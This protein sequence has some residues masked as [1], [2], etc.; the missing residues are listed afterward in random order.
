MIVCEWYD[1]NL[2]HQSTGTSANEDSTRD[3]QTPLQKKTGPIE[4]FDCQSKIHI[5][6]SDIITQQPDGIEMINDKADEN[7]TIVVHMDLPSNHTRPVNKERNVSSLD[8]TTS[9]TIQ[10]LSDSYWRYKP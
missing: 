9:S 1:E 6:H 2:S 10:H 5:K 7:G 4:E 8:K 3:G